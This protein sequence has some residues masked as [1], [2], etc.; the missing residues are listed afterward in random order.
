MAWMP[1]VVIQGQ[2]ADRRV[3]DG[4]PDRRGTGGRYKLD[5]RGRTI[6]TECEALRK[7]VR[8]T[9]LASIR[10]RSRNLSK[11]IVVGTIGQPPAWDPGGEAM[12]GGPILRRVGGERLTWVR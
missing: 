7:G 5:A 9:L 6:A 1:A 10:W 3:H 2:D 4:R 8:D 11:V 12:A